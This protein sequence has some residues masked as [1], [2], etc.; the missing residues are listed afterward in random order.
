MTELGRPRDA[1]GAAFR[2]LRSPM[3]ETGR[4]RDAGGAAFR[5]PRASFASK[6]FLWQRPRRPGRAPCGQGPLCGFY[7]ALTLAFLFKPFF[8]RSFLYFFTFAFGTFTVRD[9]VVPFSAFLPT[10]FSFLLLRV[11]V[12]SFLQP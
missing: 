3:T 4:P 9:F 5:P 6:S 2:L 11:R 1:G 12:L 7:A 8:C 10:D